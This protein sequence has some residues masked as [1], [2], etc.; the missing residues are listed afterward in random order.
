MGNAS[1]KSDNPEGE[2]RVNELTPYK[3]TQVCWLSA[4]QKP[5]SYHMYY[6]CIEIINENIINAFVLLIYET[7][8]CL[9]EKDSK[10]VISSHKSNDR[11]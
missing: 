2:L 9:K 7:T 3:S 5:P 1:E 4:K 10:C 8:K 6:N 11:H